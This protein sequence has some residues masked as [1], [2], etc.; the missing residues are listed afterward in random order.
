[1]AVLR[2]DNSTWKL[3]PCHSPRD[4]FQYYISW[5][6]SY[7]RHHTFRSWKI[8]SSRRIIVFFDYFFESSV[9]CLLDYDTM[10]SSTCDETGTDDADITLFFSDFYIMRKNHGNKK[11]QKYAVVAGISGPGHALFRLHDWGYFLL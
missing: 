9:W 6:T 5:K 11:H 4:L 3:Q 10:S 7:I 1:M 2:Q 8:H